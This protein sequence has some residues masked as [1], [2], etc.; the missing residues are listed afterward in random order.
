[1]TQDEMVGWCH[2]L[3]VHQFEQVLGVDGQGSLACY[4]PWGH[5]ESDM[6]EKSNVCYQNQQK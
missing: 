1:M 5:K 6:T 3:D 2:P 4:S